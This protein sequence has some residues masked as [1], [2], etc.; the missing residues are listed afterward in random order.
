M[1]TILTLSLF[2]MLYSPQGLARETLANRHYIANTLNEIFGKKSLK[3][4]DQ[5]ITSNIEL[6]GAPCNIYDQIRVEE[7]KVKDLKS[8][9]FDRKGN[10]KA[11]I[12]PNSSILRSGYMI[13]VC[14][15]ITADELLMNE[16]F[17]KKG[18]SSSDEFSTSNFLSIYND[19]YPFNAP[20]TQIQKSFQKIHA[21]A[22]SSTAWNYIVYGL[23]ISTKWQVI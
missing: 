2:Y 7:N 18:I 1:K 14:K 20:S 23:C 10:H 16:Y 19:F 12:R 4:T 17:M 3:Y 6:F 15:L 21:T 9:C 13:K 22:N 11:P 8:S 5:F